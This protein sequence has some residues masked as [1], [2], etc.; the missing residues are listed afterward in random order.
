MSLVELEFGY[1]VPR[2][3]FEVAAQ[4]LKVAAPMVA[5]PRVVRDGPSSPKFL[6]ADEND[7]APAR[8]AE[9]PWSFLDSSEPLG[10]SGFLRFV[11]RFLGDFS[12]IVRRLASPGQKR[13]ANPATQWPH[14]QSPS[15]LAKR[16]IRFRSKWRS[17]SYRMN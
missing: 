12:E 17:S 14:L 9:R 1:R 13:R 8:A 5:A 3:L 16:S 7:R 10:T 4:I 15:S 6:L 2:Q 11:P